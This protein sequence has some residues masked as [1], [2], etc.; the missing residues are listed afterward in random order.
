MCA[1]SGDWKPNEMSSLRVSYEAGRLVESD[2]PPTPLE[3]FE[4]WWQEAAQSGMAEPNAMVLSTVEPTGG[5]SARIVLLKGVDAAGF[6]FF[7][8]RT[9]RKARAMAGNPRVAL[10]FP[11][12]PMQRQVTVSGRA[13]P[14]SAAED[15]DY[16]HSR[17][18]DSQL[19]AWASFQSA[20]LAGRDDLER[21][22][23]KLDRRWPEGS[24]IPAPDFWGGYLVRAE[25]VEFWQGRLSRLH[26]RL[27]YEAAGP[28]SL[29]DPSLWHI[30]RYSP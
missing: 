11:W 23:A 21:R 18:R 14:M 1:V 6:R 29:D 25:A 13:E 9:S 28:S 7:T 20:P 5:P 26:D 24:R 17:P 19:A 2:L 4:R 8:N 3:L 30:R 10:V 27:R 16:F 12:H 22:M 15:A